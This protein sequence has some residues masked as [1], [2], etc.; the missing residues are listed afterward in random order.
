MHPKL[1][2]SAHD[3]MLGGVCG[4][5]AD[6]FAVESTVVRLVFA[7]SIIFFGVSPLLYIILFL[8]MPPAPAAHQHPALPMQGPTGEWRYDPYTGQPIEQP[9]PREESS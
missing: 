9:A 7:C 5:L 6:Y 3:R 4:G 1:Y 8:L 2:R